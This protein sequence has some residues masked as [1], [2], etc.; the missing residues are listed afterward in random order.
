MLEECKVGQT[1]A[2]LNDEPLEEVDRFKQMGSQV[3]AARGSRDVVYRMN[4]GY[5]VGRAQ[6]IVLSNRG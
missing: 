5:K 3:A 6:K 4:D 2:R 1:D